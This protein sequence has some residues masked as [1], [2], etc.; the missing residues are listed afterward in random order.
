MEDQLKC[1]AEKIMSPLSLVAACTVP[2][3]RYS[4][5]SLASSAEASAAGAMRIML[6]VS[7]G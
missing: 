5:S 4:D 7:V 2:T 6:A 1:G 3:S